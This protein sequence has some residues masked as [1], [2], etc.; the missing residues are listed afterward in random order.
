VLE[1]SVTYLLGLASDPAAWQ[2]DSPLGARPASPVRPAAAAADPGPAR[3]SWILGPDVPE[4]APRS[5]ARRAGRAP[6]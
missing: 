4:I 5:D 2:P 3:R 1:C 6:T